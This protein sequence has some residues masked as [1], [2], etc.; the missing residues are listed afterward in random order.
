[1]G[2]SNSDLTRFNGR[3]GGASSDLYR[4]DEANVSVSLAP[5]LSVPTLIAV[6]GAADI[7]RR[8]DVEL[9]AE[10]IKALRLGA[11]AAAI[12]TTDNAFEVTLIPVNHPGFSGGLWWSCFAPFK[13]DAR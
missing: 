6:D 13:L 11:G 5:P 3:A 7:F 10:E 1:M 2:Y 4:S 9:G 8:T 12:F